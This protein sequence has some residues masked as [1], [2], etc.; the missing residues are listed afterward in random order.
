[1]GEKSD[2]SGRRLRP[3]TAVRGKRY[4]CAKCR[5][6][7]P[8]PVITLAPWYCEKCLAAAEARAGTGENRS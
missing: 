1:M 8:Q 4:L 2:T 6:R 5:K 3:R 7:S